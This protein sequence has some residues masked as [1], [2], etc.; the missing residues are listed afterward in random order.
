MQPNFSFGFLCYVLLLI[1]VPVMSQAGSDC[2]T[3]NRGSILLNNGRMIE[4]V[5]GITRGDNGNFYLISDQKQELY[6]LYRLGDSWRVDTY[7][8]ESGLGRNDRIS[9]IEDVAYGPCPQRSEGKCIFIGEIGSNSRINIFEIHYVRVSDL[10]SP[11]QRIRTNVLKYRYPRN[12]I[13]KYSDFDSEGL[14]VHPQTGELFIVTK[15]N[16]KKDRDRDSI[17]YIYKMDPRKPN[18]LI[19]T[20]AS[21]VSA[22][23]LGKLFSPDFPNNFNVRQITGFEISPDGKRFV[24]VTY[25]ALVEF[26]VDLSKVGYGIEPASNTGIMIQK[27]DGK[28]WGKNIRAVQVESVTYD[29]SGSGFFIV[30]ENDPALMSLDCK[31]GAGGD[32]YALVSKYHCNYSNNTACNCYHNV[33]GKQCFIGYGLSK[34]QCENPASW[35]GSEGMKERISLLYLKS[36]DPSFFNKGK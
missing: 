31:A 11:N 14:S 2:A 17:S 18:P 12:N 34:Q 30:G 3:T 24:I 1:I 21:L 36:C 29:Q 8:L 15:W 23:D 28:W 7:R 35:C 33:T 4:E 32:C 10:F 16:P 13:S 19:P 6:R 22:I 26:T 20:P 27:L 9:N 25:E 5:S